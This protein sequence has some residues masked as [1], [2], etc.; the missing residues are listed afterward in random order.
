MTEQPRP[1]EEEFHAYLDGE[2]TG[3]RRRVVRAHLRDHPEEARRLEAYRADGDAIARIFSRAAELP[4]PARARP[5]LWRRAWVRAA[6]VAI[7]IAGTIAA[8][9]SWLWRDHG[10]DALWARF[11]A[12]ALVAHLSLSKA[13]SGPTM[14]ASLAQMADFFS[15]ATQTPI[16]LHEP[17]GSGYALVGSQFLIGKKG[18]VAQLAFRSRDGTLVT[19]YFEPWPRKED[20]PFKPAASQSDVTTLVWVD[21]QF[22]CAVTGALPRDEL[23][24]VG[25]TLYAE[26]VAS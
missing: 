6:A 20:A 11:G 25:R 19:M 8:G 22:G 2:L 13:S 23:E 5:Q 17:A 24:R 7:I 21:D 26:L 10:D 9:L 4:V 12:E 16:R 14:T 18:P 15:A 1:S 3:D